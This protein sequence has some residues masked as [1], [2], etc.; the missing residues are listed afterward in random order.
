METPEK[1]PIV[2]AVRAVREAHAARFNYDV[3]AIF[4][5]I[6]SRESTSGRTYV[7]WPPRRVSSPGERRVHGRF[8][9]AAGAVSDAVSK[10]DKKAD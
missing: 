2:D 4:K 1:D 8:K 7:Y 3:D 10:R 6:K 9:E 5:D